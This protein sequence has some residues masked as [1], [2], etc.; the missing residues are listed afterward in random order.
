[1]NKIYIVNLSIVYT[2]VLAILCSHQMDFTV[3]RQSQIS[4]LFQYVIVCFLI[5]I[6]SGFMMYEGVTGTGM[7]DRVRLRSLLYSLSSAYFV[8]VIS[9]GIV[10]DHAVVRQLLM[11]L[12]VASII[13]STYYK[14]SLLLHK[15]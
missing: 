14:V 9:F 3:T 2:T 5:P 6:I 12:I 1:M 15:A 4:E 8:L 7:T 13:A 11:F 10:T